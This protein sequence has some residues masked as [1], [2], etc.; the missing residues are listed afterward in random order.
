MNK[1]KQMTTEKL[2]I[3]QWTKI[4]FIG[5]LQ[6]IWDKTASMKWDHVAM[7]KE[8][9]AIHKEFFEIKMISVIV[10]IFR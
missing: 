4:T 3:I 8:N 1:Y 10:T 5:I 2:E 6:E 7:I 9:P